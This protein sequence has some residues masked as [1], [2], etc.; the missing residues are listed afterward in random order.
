MRASFFVI[1]LAI[2]AGCHTPAP[3]PLAVSPAPAPAVAIEQRVTPG[4]FVVCAIAD[5]PLP[6]PKLLAAPP[7][8]VIP[9]LPF[10]RAAAT[11]APTGDT[12]SNTPVSIRFA[13]GR[14]TLDGIA[15][16][17]LDNLLPAARTATSIIVLG[18]ADANTLAWRRA[19]AVKRYFVARG[20]KSRVIRLG[21]DQHRPSTSNAADANGRHATIE[22]IAGVPTNAA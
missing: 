13:S 22:L 3:A 5:C 11:P 14:A 16:T 18:Y 2:L 20:I 1:A 12:E 7:P 15:R 21:I 9:A 10:P 8:V 19:A 4:D 6:T 17:T